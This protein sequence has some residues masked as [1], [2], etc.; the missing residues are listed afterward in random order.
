VSRVVR[1]AAYAKLN[2]SLKVGGLRPDG[3]HEVATTL[4]AISLSDRLEFAP[5]AKG[6]ALRVDGPRARGVPR[7]PSNLVLVAARALAGELGEA[8]GAT[9]RLT[10]HVPHG[11]GLGGGSSDAAATL[12]GLLALWR[13]RLPRARLHA[14][15]ARLGSDV[16]FF[17]GSTSP[18][19]A[20]GR[21][22]RLRPLAP[23]R[24]PLRFIVLLPPRA[25][26]T[27]WAY[28]GFAGVKSRLTVRKT[29]AKLLQLHDVRER[30]SKLRHNFFN[31]LEGFVT[32]HVPEVRQAV[33]ALR[34]SGLDSARMSGSGSAVF[35][36]IPDGFPYQKVVE[37]LR[38]DG[39]RVYVGRS[40]RAGSRTCR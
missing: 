13:R 31:D 35:A 32:A 18:A 21:G 9:I 8:R 11:A 19:F 16:P 38:R 2:L 14:L 33:A 27:A 28:A 26:S 37:R 5:R 1:L 7:G 24:H 20:T 6:F 12:R 17:L 39:H 15:A 25:V 10:K 29:A 4:C 22:E 40:V 34:A 36:P 30:G 23:L 3:Y